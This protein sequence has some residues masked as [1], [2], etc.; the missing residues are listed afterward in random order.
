MEK[1]FVPPPFTLTIKCFMEKYTSTVCKIPVATQPLFT[2]AGPGGSWERE[3]AAAA[4]WA[5]L[6]SSLTCSLSC[7]H[8]KLIII[9]L[10]T[11]TVPILQIK[12]TTM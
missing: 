6:Q 2:Q 3:E 5:T 12:K 8:W 11:I 1:M 9:E 7:D 10:S 4:D